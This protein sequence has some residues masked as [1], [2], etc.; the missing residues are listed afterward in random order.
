MHTFFANAFNS[1]VAHMKI[2]Q[3]EA[4]F[5]KYCISFMSENFFEITHDIFI[6]RNFIMRLSDFMKRFLLSHT[7][8]MN[9]NDDE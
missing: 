2:E 4:R 6:V 1:T 3:S 9:D 5:S 8:H 7:V